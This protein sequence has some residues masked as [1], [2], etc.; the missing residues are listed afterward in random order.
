MIDVPTA[1]DKSITVPAFALT[2][3]YTPGLGYCEVLRSSCE[4]LERLVIDMGDIQKVA[5]RA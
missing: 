2:I 5:V 3:L 4:R 1:P